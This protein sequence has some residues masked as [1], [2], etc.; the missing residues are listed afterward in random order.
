MHMGRQICWTGKVL[1]LHNGLLIFGKYITTLV[2]AIFDIQNY[3][4]GIFICM[5]FFMMVIKLKL[6]S[7]ILLAVLA[8]P[9]KFTMTCPSKQHV[10]RS[11]PQGTTYVYQARVVPGDCRN[12]VDGGNGHVYGF[13]L[14]AVAQT[15]SVLSSH[16]AYPEYLIKY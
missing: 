11:S 5:I 1:N 12:Y 10:T 3:Y 15:Y 13:T 14:N 4:T 6:F 7:V 9:I 8:T 16:Q 2:L